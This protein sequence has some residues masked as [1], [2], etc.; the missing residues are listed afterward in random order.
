MDD[1]LEQAPTESNRGPSDASDAGSAESP[2]VEVEAILEEIVPGFLSE[3]EQDVEQMQT[4]LDEG[5]FESIREI[6]HDL[7]G[8]GAGYGFDRVTDF[9]KT[10]ETAAR[11]E[12][13]EKLRE[14]IAELD[15]YVADVEVTFVE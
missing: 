2:V 3:L 15:S 4:H 9:G 1:E 6:A 11:S 13:E 5:D 7:K 14:T 10:I 8:S 12:D